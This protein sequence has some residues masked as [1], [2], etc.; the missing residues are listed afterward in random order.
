MTEALKNIIKN[1]PEKPG[2]YQYFD[3]KG[4]IIYV[5]KA[6][7]L[8]KRVSSY[9]TKS[10]DDSPKTRVLVSKIHDIK[11]IVVDTEEDTFLLENNLIKQFRPRYNV[12]LKDD[13]SYPSIVI[14]NEN[15]PRIHQTR[16]IIRDGSLYFGPYTSVFAIKTMME[17]IH[18]LYPIRTCKLNLAPE[19]IAKGKYK[20]CLEY[21]IKRCKGACEGLQSEE[22]YNQNI[23]RIKEIL[24]GNIAE[25]SKEILQ[26][27]EKKASELKFEEAHLLKEKYLQIDAF[28]TKSTVVSQITYNIDVFSYD[29]D[30]NSAYINYMHVVNGAI[31]QAFTFQY[32]KVLNEEKEYMLG[33][34]IVEMRS[35]F[36]SNSKEIIVPFIPD[37]S[38]NNVIFSIPQR[39]D[40]RKLLELSEQNV[41]QYKLDQLKKAESL[42]PDQ[43]SMRLM[44]ELQTS[45]GMPQTP[46]HIECFD[47]SNLQGTSPVA[48]CVVFRKGKPSKKE[49][50]KYHIKSVV[51]ADDYA[52]MQE[53]V[54][55]RYKRMQEEGSLLPDLILT[56]GGKGQ[57]EVVRRVI[58][59]Q[60]GLQIPIAG[61]A[62]DTRHR[63]SEVWFGFP[64]QAIGIKQGTP[65]FHFLEHV[66]SEV[67]RFAITFHK[68]VRSKAQTRSQL[69]NIP[70]IGEATR[71]KLMQH[72]K[73]IKRL[74]SAEKQEVED[75]VGKHKA[76]IIWEYFQK[77]GEN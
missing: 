58:E 3:D 64:P 73:S 63:T 67:H 40:K 45:L 24:K 39:G 15:F 6:K 75:I 69:D 29:E 49:Y 38:L 47:N 14:R 77:E 57:M 65:I 48:A 50:R 28:R 13:K 51:G 56:D 42:N 17:I 2:C 66:Q 20:V 46:M 74:K 35:R 12:L 8:K 7:N 55:R 36:G 52:S 1:I 60:L 37:L 19:A 59:E 30:E 10:H 32:K 41:K 61:L 72:F 33:M 25:V 5:G 68:Q 26:E 23:A 21:H 27:M 76:Q 70:G 53:V 16:K 54:F 31:N 22:E 4:T 9:F 18:K 71:H 43:R 11:Y 62:K 44:K 34:G